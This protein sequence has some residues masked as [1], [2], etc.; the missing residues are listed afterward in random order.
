MN[1]TLLVTGGAGYIGSHFCKIAKQNGY[2]VVAYDNLSTGFQKLVK[3]GDFVKGDIKNY[4]LLV[5]TFKKYKPI[6]VIHFAA[7][8]Q[9]GE[10]VKFPYKYYDNNTAGTLNLLKAMIDCDIKNLIFSS[11]C[12]TFGNPDISQINENTPQNPINPY[13]HSKLMIEKIL[14]DFDYAYNFK[15][16]AL[17][18]FNAS[19]SDP[20][21]ETGECHNPPFHLIPIICQT[22]LGIREKMQI[23]GN[24]YKT[25]D[26]TCIRDYVHVLD[27]SNAHILALQ[28]L[29]ENKKSMKINLGTNKGFSNLELVQTTEK[30][31]G[32]K[33]NYTFGEIREGDPAILVCDNTLAKK[34]LGWNIK[35]SNIE[36][37]IK[38]TLEWQK[39][40]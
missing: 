15:Y 17:R 22:A 27:L 11:T 7:F 26:G 16:T 18:Y 38:H 23:F 20:D 13:G 34:Y 3:W 19:G 28:K 2:N 6:A 14:E 21:L 5:E 30:I 32:H 35:Y 40:L 33:I 24:N 25:P 12:A 1:S 39:L 4:N 10:S 29:L 31:I 36:D 37:H 8:A 9:V